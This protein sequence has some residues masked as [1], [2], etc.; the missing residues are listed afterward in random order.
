MVRES[1][2]KQDR[3]TEIKDRLLSEIQDRWEGDLTEYEPILADLAMEYSEDEV[4]QA[5]RE[6]ANRD[7]T[8]DDQA[9]RLRLAVKKFRALGE[10]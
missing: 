9:D 7:Q 6:L 3:I 2:T 1:L 10:K 8:D 4:A 5:A